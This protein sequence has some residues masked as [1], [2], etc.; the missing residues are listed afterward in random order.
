MTQDY[1]VSELTEKSPTFDL[2]LVSLIDQIL[3][4]AGLQAGG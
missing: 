1:L 4:K 2:A 3:G